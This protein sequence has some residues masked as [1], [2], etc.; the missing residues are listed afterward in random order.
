MVVHK[1]SPVYCMHVIGP[2]TLSCSGIVTWRSHD[3]SLLST[4]LHVWDVPFGGLGGNQPTCEDVGH[5]I[6]S[7]TCADVQ[8][9]EA[10]HQDVPSVRLQTLLKNPTWEKWK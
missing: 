7:T 3:V 5:H 6:T 1:A 9:S 4:N 8:S 10:L 2:S